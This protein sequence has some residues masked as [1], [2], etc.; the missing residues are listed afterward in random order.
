MH[1][2]ARLGAADAHHT[3]YLRVYI[4]QLRKKLEAVPGSYSAPRTALG[5]LLMDVSL[6][7]PNQRGV[8]ICSLYDWSKFLLPFYGELLR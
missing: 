7:R 4:R 6:K 2:Y 1:P 3:E 8:F 5:A